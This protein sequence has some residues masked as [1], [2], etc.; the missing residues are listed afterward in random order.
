MISGEQYAERLTVQSHQPKSIVEFFRESPPVGVKLDLERDQD[1]R[2]DGSCSKEGERHAQ[3]SALVGRGTK[4]VSNP[5]GCCLSS[6]SLA[7]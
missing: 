7:P 6:T 5:W 1:P 2:N 4:C 3:K